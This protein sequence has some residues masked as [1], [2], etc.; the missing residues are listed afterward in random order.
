MREVNIKDKLQELGHPV[1]HLSLGDFDQI[2]HFTAYKSRSSDSELY[3]SKGCFFRP[4]YER[5]MLIYSLI[6]KYN[7]KSYLEIGFGRGY[8]CIC[9]AKAMSEIG[10]GVITTIDPFFDYGLWDHLCKIFPI[11]WTSQVKT[12]REKSQEYLAKDTSSYD[13]IYIDGDH[14]VDAVQA[15]WENTKDKYNKVLL[16]DD[17]RKEQTQPEIECSKVIDKIED[18]SKELIIMDRRIFQDDR[19]LTDDQINYGQV[20]LFK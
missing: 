16:F 6:K 19:D 7:I 17:Y 3:H 1:E 15:D 5:G 14:T 11:E 20:I 2:G 9:A 4:N 13:F 12:V 10:G 18:D 8:S